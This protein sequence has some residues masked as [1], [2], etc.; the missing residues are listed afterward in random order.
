MPRR[1]PSSTRSPSARADRASVARPPRFPRGGRANRHDRWLWRALGC[2]RLPPAGR[3]HAMI[4]RLSDV[5]W[6]ALTTGPFHPSPSS[7]ADQ[8][9]YFLLVDR[10]SDGRENGYRDVN[11]R[12][13]AGTTPPFSTGDEEN[14]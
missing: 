13:V 9:L 6:T 11:G 10:F 14:A 1:V 5:D 8:V 2:D 12:P 7:W 3:G 4:E